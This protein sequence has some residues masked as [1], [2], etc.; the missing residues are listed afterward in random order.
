MIENIEN[1]TLIICPSNFKSKILKQLSAEKKILNIS[2]LSIEEYKKNYYFDYDYRAIKYLCDK[3]EYSVDNSKEIIDNLYY[4]KDV[5]YHNNKLNALVSYKKELD[6]FLIYNPL[7]KEYLKN[8]KTV[9]MGYGKLNEFDKTM[10]NDASFIEYPYINKKY[11]IKEFN[12]IDKEVECVYNAIFDLL[13]SG[14]DINRIHI[15]N[16]NEEYTSYLK[17]YNSYCPFKIYYKSKD[18]L[19]G[20]DITKD[21]LSKLDNR[22]ELYN[23]LVNSN[24][25]YANRLINIINKY[26]EV[27]LLDVKDLIINDLKNSYIDDEYSNVVSCDNMF[28][29]YDK[30]DY[31]F[32]LGFNDALPSMK[33]DNDYI[34]NNIRDL[35]GLP[36]IEQENVLIKENTINYLSSIDNLYLSY[37]KMTPFSKHEKQVLFS[38]VEYITVLNDNKHSDLLNR[39]KYSLMLDELNKYGSLDK[40]INAM[41]SSYSDNDYDTYDNCFKSYDAGIKEVSLSYTSLQSYNECAFSY[42]LDKVLKVDDNLDNFSTYFG[43][44]THYVLEK[45]LNDNSLDFDKLWDEGINKYNVSFDCKKDEFFFNKLKEEIREDIDV[46]KDQKA[47]CELNKQECERDIVVKVNDNTS[48]KGKID[49]I[50]KKD[51]NVCIIDYKTGNNKIEEGLFEYGLSLQLP[52]YLYLLKNTE[53]YKNSKV[54]GYYLQHLLLKNEDKKYE[55]D[56]TLYD[57]RKK[58]LKLDGYS[59]NDRS[60]IYYIDNAIDTGYKSEVIRSMTITKTKDDFGPHSKVV[61]DEEIEDTV[62]L[63]KDKV[64]EAS[65]NILNNRFDINPK[66]YGNDNISCA[67]CKMSDI[68][69]K[70]VKDNVYLKKKKDKV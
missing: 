30:E 27:D 41:Y 35:V 22:E 14:V 38:N 15:L 29:L 65:D 4:V 17:R 32:L 16:L 58:A 66:I 70:R 46:I 54:V 2:F 36:L 45:K 26:V 50:L 48:F 34:T 12:N 20:L 67:Y 8:K 49:K 28:T 44:V 31:V 40:D 5:D 33:K 51:D 56:T 7:F 6:D 59:S 11:Q 47:Y 60:R 57:K 53:E 19:Y 63:V 62:N 3:Y 25:K 39:Y 68:C 10:F 23:Y 64:I 52:S 1:N 69:F 42:Y 61:S 13:K 24:N 9:V 37:S 55:D 43:S 21:F 18:S